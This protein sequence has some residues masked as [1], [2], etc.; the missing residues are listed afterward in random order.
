MYCVRC[1]RKYSS[2]ALI[3]ATCREPLQKLAPA[4]KRTRQR[5]GRP[6]HRPLT[7]LFCDLV[8]STGMSERLDPEE[9]IQ[10]LDVYLRHCDEI[11]TD[12]GG[13]LA[14]YLG[15]AILAYFGYPQAN[16]DDAV[17]AV[18]AGLAILSS[19]GSLDLPLVAPL[20]AR[21][22][23][24]TG[25]VIVSDRTSQANYRATEIVGTMP[26]LAA[27]LQSM[28][29]PGE[30]VIANS[31][32]RVTR[33]AFTYRDL[34]AV[35]LKG[36]AKPVQAWVV[37]P[38][39][40]LQSRFHARLQGDVLPFVGRQNELEILHKS[41]TEARSGQGQVVQVVGEAGIGKSR[42]T[43]MLEQQLADQAHL[44]IRLYCS[45][46]H[47]DSTLYP[48][49][50]Y[51]QRVASF[52]RQD[53]SG[54][55]VKK[56]A[57]LLLQS[58][59]YPDETTMAAIAELLSVPLDRR[60]PLDMLTPEKRKEV[61]MRALLAQF[62][63]MSAATPV[64]MVVEDL[65]WIDVT[66]LELLQLLVQQRRNA[67]VLTI[68]TARPEFKLRWTERRSVSVLSLGRLDTA[69]S[70]E[71]CR[72]AA[73]NVLSQTLLRKIVERSDGIPL[74]VE[75]LTRTVVEFGGIQRGRNL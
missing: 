69:S 59:K 33:G 40:T 60:S 21:A 19:I 10:A 71:L 43:E 9:L 62:V 32:R 26:N 12:H 58:G 3:C 38:S 41:W 15:D 31:T 2:I 47:S 24:A 61:T 57:R 35:S 65:Q 8:D 49:I 17:N 73:G 23:I 52:E 45:P 63:R 22:G 25:L 70:E 39:N 18:S 20:Q 48:V 28:A 72:H 30:L 7:A 1:K 68:L 37:A 36:F 51:L 74:Y 27:R 50:E 53:D 29:R 14:R 5:P 56:L 55:R 67:R 46:Q 13:F 75:E 64:I 54:D 34:G 16:E 66:T 11:V 4:R 6:Q 44:C 42:L